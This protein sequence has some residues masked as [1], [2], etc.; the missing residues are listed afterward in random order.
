MKQRKAH[1]FIGFVLIVLI[2]T[3]ALLS[4]PDFSV[5]LSYRMKTAD[6][7]VSQASYWLCIKMISFMLLAALYVWVYLGQSK[8][9]LLRS[10]EELRISNE[11]Y[12]IVTEQADSIIFDYNFT[13]KTIILSGNI[14]RK[15][16]YD[17]LID[18]FPQK[19]INS[20][21]I[22][23]D[24]VK[25][26]TKLCTNVISGT[27]YEECELRIKPIKGDYIWCRIRA[28]T[29]FDD[30]HKPVNAIGKIIDIDKQKRETLNLQAKAQND[31]LTSLYNKDTTERLITSCLKKS[32]GC[33]HALFIMDIDNF[34]AI[35]DHL[36]HIFGDSVLHDISPK[37]KKLFRSSDV[38]G[39]IGGD[40]FMVL[41]KDFSSDEVVKEKANAFCTLLRQTYTGENNDYAISGS[42]GIA[43]YPTDGTTYQQLYKKADA[44][45]YHAKRTG[46][47]SYALYRE[48]Y[49]TCLCAD[50]T[51]CEKTTQE[52]GL[53]LSNEMILDHIPCL[54]YV[55]D[56]TNY[57][58][59]YINQKTRDLVPEIRLG[60]KCYAS[61]WHLQEPCPSCP[62]QGL[63]EKQNAAS[64]ELYN[65]QI[66]M[67]AL[68]A[69]SKIDWEENRNAV[70][71]CAN[72][73][74]KYKMQV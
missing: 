66:H 53:L 20:P 37:I 10:N 73:I 49:D 42:I 56:Q 29:V 36:G 47:S 15:L 16:G 35:N 33:R 6:A 51:D 22:H 70:L 27:P 65:D 19:A 48:E 68:T 52:K 28:T 58:L 31:P 24:D 39:R 8:K 63:L 50:E 61:L 5:L 44:A 46:K 40:E 43:I 11:R 9:A 45:L 60:E 1:Y 30:H 26:L 55:I 21:A 64:L 69:A 38:V 23:I 67:W 18:N 25:I 12:R 41:M 13:D 4:I 72:D 74:T 57:N 54:A 7:E 59:L 3:N 71:L 2:F 34:K 17:Y 32:S 14:K 62:I